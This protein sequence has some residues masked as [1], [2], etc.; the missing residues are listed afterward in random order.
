M[1]N[2]YIEPDEVPDVYY[3]PQTPPVDVREVHQSIYDSSWRGAD[4]FDLIKIQLEESRKKHPL[5]KDP[6]QKYSTFSS[7]MVTGNNTSKFQQLNEIVNQLPGAPYHANGRDN[8]LTFQ[9]S[10]AHDKIVLSYTYAGGNGE[11]LEFG[12]DTDFSMASPDITKSTDI[13]PDDKTLNTEVNQVVANTNAMYQDGKVVNFTPWKLGPIIM[14]RDNTEIL[15]KRYTGPTTGYSPSP[16]EP[17]NLTVKPSLGKNIIYKGEQDAIKDIGEN[18]ELSQADYDAYSQKLEEWV[19]KSNDAQTVEEFH[20]QIRDSNNLP[21]YTIKRLVTVETYEYPGKY[22]GSNPKTLSKN[23]GFVADTKEQWKRGFKHLKKQSGYTIIPSVTR[24]PNDPYLGYD[25]GSSVLV[26]KSITVE[27]PIPG[28]RV[29]ASYS[30]THSANGLVGDMVKRAQS[31]ITA[32][33]KVIGN[34]SIE[35][36]MN[37]EI[38]NV[39]DRYSG[40]WYT[41]EVTHSFD[42][43]GYTCEIEFIQKSLPIT[44]SKT[45]GTVST[46]KMYERENGLREAAKKA[47]ETKSH[48]AKAAIIK[49]FKKEFRP[50]LNKDKNYL[51]QVDPNNPFKATVYRARHDMGGWKEKVG[52]IEVDPNTIKDNNY[53]IMPKQ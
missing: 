8:K 3:T 28:A 21:D 4:K 5:P 13:D 11:L 42:K 18:Y 47:L 10:R 29:L 25:P 22:S 17:A 14:P 43:S 2:D 15:D 9:N 26:R 32:T 52:V 35:S 12:V 45:H 37:I 30:P 53:G 51:V 19:K 31:K 39:S 49:E 46:V 1:A 6:D 38:L 27:I 44:L 23:S 7:I 48:L 24:H 33:A 16:N 36:S 40:V 41:K 50:D 34:P 20:S